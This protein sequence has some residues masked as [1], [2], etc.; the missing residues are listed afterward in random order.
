MAESANISYI[1]AG[2]FEKVIDD[3][4]SMVGTEEFYLK[5]G[6]VL[7]TKSAILGHATGD[8]SKE[9][10]EA[11]QRIDERVEEFSY[12]YDRSFDLSVGD[13]VTVG[14]ALVSTIDDLKTEILEES[15]DHGISIT[16]AMDLA[17]KTE[18]DLNEVASDVS[19]TDA[20]FKEIDQRAKT[21]V[22]KKIV[23]VA[24]TASIAEKR[25]ADRENINTITTSVRKNAQ[26]KIRVVDEKIKTIEEKKVK[27]SEQLRDIPDAKEIAITI[28]DSM[29]DGLLNVRDAMVY[30]TKNPLEAVKRA[31]NVT[32]AVTQK[33]GGK[34]VDA[35]KFVWEHP[36][37]TWD[38]TKE[39][40]SQMYRDAR[41][42]PLISGLD[43]AEYAPLIGIGVEGTRDFYGVYFSGEK[44][45]RPTV[46]KWRNFCIITAIG[47]K[48][49]RNIVGGIVE[50]ATDVK[51]VVTRKVVQHPTVNLKPKA[52]IRIQA[53]YD[54]V[55][56]KTNKIP[57]G[58]YDHREVFASEKTLKNFKRGTAKLHTGPLQ[59]DL[60]IINF[61]DSSKILGKR[62]ADGRSLMWFTHVNVGNKIPTM[63]DV[64]Q[65]LALLRDWGTR[66]AVTLVKIPKGT[67]INMI[68]GKAVKQELLNETGKILEKVKG[69]GFQTFVEYIDPSW[70]IETRK[71]PK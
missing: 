17:Q 48:G 12:S 66:D 5:V 10:I 56:T 13:F 36:Q 18:S 15:L 68:S 23:E 24:E 55:K 42:N 16:E 14:K 8:K 38:L 39:K 54:V 37:E 3:F 46:D 45:L 50:T 44:E 21:E 53:Q 40:L 62:G 41:E 43:L 47:G 69:G 57:K 9:H 4:A 30:V 60:Y 7:H 63:H 32:V 31:W 29:R 51:K 1:D 58:S 59:E 34:A 22:E 25:R 65:H 67:S 11:S 20:T 6:N 33:V 70:I 52:V 71:L 19:S 49:L 26:E 27:I 35:T 2:S 61:H 64:H 28:L